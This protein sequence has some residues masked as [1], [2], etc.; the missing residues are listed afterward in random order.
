MTAVSPTGDG[1]TVR[2]ED[3]TIVLIGRS[4]RGDFEAVERTLS[5]N[6]VSGGLITGTWQGIVIVTA[7]DEQEELAHVLDFGT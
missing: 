7:A 3:E 4:G 5:F 1:Q 6:C 2:I